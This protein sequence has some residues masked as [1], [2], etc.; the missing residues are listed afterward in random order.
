MPGSIQMPLLI[1]G[2]ATGSPA[3]RPT[4]RNAVG[5]DRTVSAL[6]SGS[7]LPAGA[8]AQRRVE[9]QGIPGFRIVL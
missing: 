7:G 3:S 2:L 8:I 6:I 9:A 1:S 4:D 5:G